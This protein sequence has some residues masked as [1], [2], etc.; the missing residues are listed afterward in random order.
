[1]R[2]AQ[3]VEVVVLEVEDVELRGLHVVLADSLYDGSSP[4]TMNYWGGSIREFVR[5]HI[6]AGLTVEVSICSSG[7]QCKKLLVSLDK[8][9]TVVLTK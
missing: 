9:I 1:M 2:S 6:C 3:Q 8:E 4:L 7:M 5:R